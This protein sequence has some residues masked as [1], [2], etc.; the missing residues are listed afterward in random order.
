MAG[1]S[2]RTVVVGVRLPVEVAKKARVNAER[3]KVTLS[4]YLARIL[5]LQ[6]GRRR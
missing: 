2:T 5:V 1:T 3:G 6:V 4:Q